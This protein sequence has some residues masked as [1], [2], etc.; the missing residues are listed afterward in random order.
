M[1]NGR[2]RILV[3]PRRLILNPSLMQAQSHKQARP[4]FIARVVIL[5]ADQLGL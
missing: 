3:L 4:G 2:F 1:E 5:K